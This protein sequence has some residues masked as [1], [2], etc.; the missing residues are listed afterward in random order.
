MTYN[1]DRY[2]IDHNEKSGYMIFERIGGK[3][4][5][6]YEFMRFDLLED[7]EIMIGRKG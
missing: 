2:K 7:A 4:L 5:R 6:L 3:W 1:P